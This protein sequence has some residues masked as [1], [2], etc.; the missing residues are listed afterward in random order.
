MS[1]VTRFAPS[2][3]GYLHLGHAFSALQRLAA[4]AAR[5]AGGS[6]C[7]WRISIPAA[8][9]P[10]S[11]LRSRRTWPGWAWTGTGRC[12]CSRGIC[13]NISAVLDALADAGLLY[14]C[15]CT[16]ADIAAGDRGVAAAPHGPDGAPLYPGTCRRLSPAERAARIAAGE[17][18]A[19]RL[20]MAAAIRRRDCLTRRKAR[21]ASPAT[22]TV[23]R[24]GAGAEGRAGELSSVRD[25]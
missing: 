20:D 25:A 13:R 12:G 19:L 15:F 9:A 14:P 23:R 5:P 8:A 2:P 16:R 22:R 11:P 24:R 17:R 4:G 10:N 6:C 3:T 7:G 1:I 18:F 21:A